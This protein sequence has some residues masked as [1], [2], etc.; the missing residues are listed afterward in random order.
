VD[1]SLKEEVLDFLKKQQSTIHST[2]FKKNKNKSK[3][4]AKKKIKK[5]SKKDKSDVKKTSHQ[6]RQK[7]KS[8]E[9]TLKSLTAEV[10]VSYII[11][12]KD[13]KFSKK[14]KLS[15]GAFGTVFKGTWQ[16]TD[17]AIKKL[18]IKNIPEIT[19]KIFKEEINIMSKLRHPNV[20][21]LY[22]ACVEPGH[23]CIVM[24]YM[25]NGS[26][27]DILHSDQKLPW[28]Q[29]WKI[30]LEVGKGIYHLHKQNIL[31]RD[32]K[33]LNVLLDEHMT[34]K[35]CDF[36][37]SRVKEETKATTTTG[38]TAQSVG[39]TAWM[40]PELFEREAKYTKACDIY[41]YGMVLWEIASRKLPWSD[42]EDANI[43]INW[44]EDGEQEDIPEKTPL[45]YAKLIKWCWEKEPDER[46]K[47]KQ[48]VEMLQE[49]CQ[50]V[51]KTKDKDND[52][53]NI[54]KTT[55]PL[56]Y[57]KNIIVM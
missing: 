45:S 53:Q 2:P 43:I 49:N 23:Y 5:R 48:A 17:V 52:E 25:P 28:S 24:P 13:I 3:K 27:Y 51:L 31:H 34:A 33:S 6:V 22:G 38:K 41:S 39:T 46:P 8:N 19:M 35:V 36:G 20:L 14:D 18:H 50:E 16:F 11:S 44:I 55:K 30:A 1:N 29:R 57:K 21:P 54:E 56:N 26:L 40:A 10:S 4:K 15:S 37:I 32:L 47:I 7:E 42:A 12:Y 9:S